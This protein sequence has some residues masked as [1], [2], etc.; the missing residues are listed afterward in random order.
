[1]GIVSESGRRGYYAAARGDHGDCF[2]KQDR[3]GVLVEL[4]GNET[5]S[6]THQ[7]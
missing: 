5:D 3:A 6:I 2:L 4:N 7:L 1:M